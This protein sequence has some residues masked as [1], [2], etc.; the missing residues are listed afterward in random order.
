MLNP[1]LRDR[2]ALITGANHGIGAATAR[3]LAAQGCRVFVTY[4]RE[5]VTETAEDS[6]AVIA[7]GIGGPE[8]YRARQQQTPDSLLEHPLDPAPVQNPGER[9]VI[10]E[11]VQ[12]L[13]RL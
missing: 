13:A 3:A 2:V 10:G 11:E 7:A 5:P 9:V 6:A 1:G 12:P 4:Y 8:L